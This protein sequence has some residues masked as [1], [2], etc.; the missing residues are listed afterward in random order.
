MPIIYLCQTK[1]IV[2]RSLNININIS[3]NIELLNYNN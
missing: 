1:N 2:K 3:E